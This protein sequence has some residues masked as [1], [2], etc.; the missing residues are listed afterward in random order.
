M[1]GATRSAKWMQGCKPCFFVGCFTCQ[2]HRHPSQTTS[3]AKQKKKKQK[4]KKQQ[5][6]TRKT[7]TALK[8]ENKQTY[9]Q[10]SKQTSRQAREQNKIKQTN[11]QTNKQKGPSDNILG[12]YHHRFPKGNSNILCHE[13]QQQLFVCVCNQQLLLK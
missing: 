9:I 4:Q 1:A 6:L 12:K 2:K 13:E 11:K 10:A 8:R 7:A 3:H 5:P